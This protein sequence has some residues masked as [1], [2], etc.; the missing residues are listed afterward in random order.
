MVTIRFPNKILFEMELKNKMEKN[1]HLEKLG[2]F[3][4]NQRKNMKMNQIIFY[5]YLFPEKNL[6]DENIK[7]KMNSI[8]N[9]KGKEMN[10]ELLFRLRE[11][12]DVSI[13]YLLGFEIEYPNYEN[14]AACEYTGLKPETIKQL[15]FW[16]K[17]LMMN[18]PEAEV[19]MTDNQLE[20]LYLKKTRIS[21]AKWIFE[22][23]N[24]LFQPK[25]QTDI[26]EG[27]SDLTV[28]YDLYMMS[29][30]KT[31]KIVGIP[32]DIANS[33][34]SWFDQVGNNIALDPES[35]SFADSMNEI[36]TVNI[37][38]ITRKI[39]EERLLKDINIMISCMD[40]Q[41]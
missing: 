25:S 21:E 18:E 37:K 41:E 10:Y 33:G 19:D 17:Y 39:W 7:K 1:L 29:F 11:K 13:D 23:T 38:E 40:M 20:E 6:N 27:I 22:I 14:K 2:D 32:L 3:V 15:H 16:S 5:K 9:G 28:L 26:K 30:D 31:K 24:L 12:F 34:L 35:L 8:E 4:R 36:H